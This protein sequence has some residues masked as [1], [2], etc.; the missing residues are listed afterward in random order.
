MIQELYGLGD[1][2]TEQIKE[3]VKIVEAEN[4]DP[5]EIYYR[6]PDAA[7]DPETFISQI[8]LDEVASVVPDAFAGAKGPALASRLTLPQLEQ[9]GIDG[10]EYLKEA[11]K[12]A[13]AIGSFGKP[14]DTDLKT[15][16]EYVNRSPAWQV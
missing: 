6:R 5:K 7:P 11:V 1:Y 9:I 16:K 13:L 2:N 12:V 10:D 4:M 15:L 8:P 14:D 3:F